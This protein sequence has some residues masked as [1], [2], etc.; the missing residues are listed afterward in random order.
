MTNLQNFKFVFTAEIG[1]LVLK[2]NVSSPTFVTWKR[3]I[4]HLSHRP[5]I[6]NFSNYRHDSWE[7]RL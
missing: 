6:R 5:V 2:A 1:E 3:S 4:Y 7:G